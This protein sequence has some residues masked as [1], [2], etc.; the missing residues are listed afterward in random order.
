MSRTAI[1]ESVKVD[2]L[3]MTEQ[4]MSTRQISERTGVSRNTIMKV[5]KESAEE[6]GPVDGGSKSG[7]ISTVQARA[8]D[9]TP[10]QKS[11]P[12]NEPKSE[13]E[14]SQKVSHPVTVM[15]ITSITRDATIRELADLL[16]SA[17]GTLMTARSNNDGTDKAINAEVQATRAVKDILTQMGRWCGLD[18]TITESKAES[19][20]IHD[21]TLED[22]VKLLEVH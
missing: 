1:A 18:G 11:E 8:R 6:D 7:S 9:Y 14:L 15:S 20:P 5:I 22:C 2:I 10:A 16:E 4:G 21:L 13:P 3:Y 19:K 17:K 12:E